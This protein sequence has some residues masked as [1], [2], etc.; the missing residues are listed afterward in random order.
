MNN[1]GQLRCL[2]WNAPDNLI[3]TANGAMLKLDNQK[4]QMEG[5]VCV[6][7]DKQQQP[8]L[9][10]MSTGLSVPPPT[11]SWRYSKNFLVGILHKIE[12]MVRHNKRGYQRGP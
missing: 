7:Q 2:P 1:R 8:A 9:P 5:C 6:P 10:G 12:S 11:A 4:K 3:A